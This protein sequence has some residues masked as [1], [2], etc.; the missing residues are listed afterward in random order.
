MQH[1][2]ETMY[3]YLYARSLMGRNT[4]AAAQQMTEIV[5]DHPDFA[6]AHGSLAEIYASVLFHDESKEKAERERFLALCPG[7]GGQ[8]SALQQRPA[9]LPEPSVLVDQAE[10]LLTQYADPIRV[11]AIAEQG[12]RDD[13]WRLQR[14]RPF[15]WYTVD[16]KRQ[17]QRDLQ[18]KYWRMWS[19]EVRCYRRAGQP[20]KAAELLAVMEQ[21]AVSLHSGTDPIYWDALATLIRLYEEGKQKDLAT[22]KLNSMQ[23]FLAM[24]PDPRHSAQLEDLRKLADIQ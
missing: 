22:Q 15:D 4:S 9:G 5:A 7:P 21:R 2:D 14:I 13:E 17:A 16:Y 8:R 10:S 3:S 24:H 6:P 1:P 12:V 23:E 19:I 11:A 20:E 18:A